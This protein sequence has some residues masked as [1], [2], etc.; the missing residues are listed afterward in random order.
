MLCMVSNGA[1]LHSKELPKVTCRMDNAACSY[2]GLTWSCIPSLFRPSSFALM[3]L[4][5]DPRL[6]V[7]FVQAGCL[8]AHAW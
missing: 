1:A 7:V 6:E 2:D 4:W 5:P 8:G 3:W